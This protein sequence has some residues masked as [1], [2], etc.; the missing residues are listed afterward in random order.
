MERIN[1]IAPDFEA[2]LKRK[3]GEKY[4]LALLLANHSMTRIEGSGGRTIAFSTLEQ[5]AKITKRG[6]VRE[7]KYLTE[8]EIERLMAEARKG[9]R[10]LLRN[11]VIS[12]P[13]GHRDFGLEFCRVENPLLVCLFEDPR[14]V[15][16][17]KDIL[18]HVVYENGEL[19][20]DMSKFPEMPA[21]PLRNLPKDEDFGPLPPD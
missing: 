15:D 8:A 21:F 14:I 10:Y 1:R 19:S 7:D 16:T 13:Q 6:L 18:S 2:S 11:E 5:C 17:T 20:W 3:F 4:E 9:S 12:Q